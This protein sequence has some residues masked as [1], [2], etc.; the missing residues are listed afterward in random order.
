M[1]LIGKTHASWQV[2]NPNQ[3]SRSWLVTV[4]A[5]LGCGLVCALVVYGRSRDPSPLAE[6]QTQISELKAELDSQRQHFSKVQSDVQRLHDEAI[7]RAAQA[8]APAANAA[9]EPAPSLARWMAETTVI[10]SNTTALLARLMEQLPA[11]SKPILSAEQKQ[12]A[13]R[14]LIISTEQEATKLAELK[15]S[16]ADL[17]FQ[18]GVPDE[19]ATLDPRQGLEMG[20][21]KHYWPYFEAK[22]RRDDVERLVDSLEMKL[23]QDSINAEIQ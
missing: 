20:S 8:N 2:I 1:L 10:Q 14:T 21:L 18:L 7:L 6:I 3:Q 16:T 4:I 17:L 13:Y 19:V 23:L 11:A 15:R 9:Q 5:V 12:A 22:I